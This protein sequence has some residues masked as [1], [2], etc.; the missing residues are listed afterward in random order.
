MAQPVK[1]SGTYQKPRSKTVKKR[2]TPTKSEIIKRNI[3]RGKKPH[4]KF[5]TSKLE[6]RFATEIL[7]KL[8]IKYQWQYYAP[9]IKR[10]FDYYLTEYQI[11]I[12]ID[13]TYWHGK[14][15]TY[16]EKNPTQKKNEYVD[17]VKNYWAAE[18]GIVLIRIWEDDINER[19]AMVC[20][21]LRERLGIQEEK[22][23]IKND[24]KKRH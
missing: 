5:G 11:L 15:L 14:G 23:R 21:M 8:G 9:D 17:K 16:E 13:G 7:D 19:P 6:K 3:E 20:D 10:Y 2:R 12:E 24:K 4:P 1:K 22:L 18:H